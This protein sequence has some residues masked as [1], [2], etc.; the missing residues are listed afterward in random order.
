MPDSTANIYIADLGRKDVIS[1]GTGERYYVNYSW[2][3]DSTT[4]LPV[5]VQ[6]S[7]TH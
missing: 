1:P 6:V 4:L 3:I 7:E 5:G 2:Q